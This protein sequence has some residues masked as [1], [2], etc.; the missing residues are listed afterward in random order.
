MSTVAKAV[1]LLDVLGRGEP[2][3]AL[4]DLARVAGFDKATTRRLLVALI[5]QGLVEQDGE[6][7]LYRLGVGIA[8][9]ALLRETQ[10]P[11]LRTATPIAQELAATTGETV[12]FSEHS[13]RGLVSIYV[14]ESPRAN[15][16]V[17]PLGEILPLHAT[18]SG[19]AFLA[20]SQTKT[21]ATALSG[22]LE[23]YTPHTVTD[24]MSVR[25]L[26]TAA[27][28]RGYSIG[29]Q[30]YEDGVTSV[31]API[32]GARGVAVGAIAIAAPRT[33]VQTGD[34]ETL[35]R[36]VMRAAAEISERLTGRRAKAANE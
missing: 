13:S 1:A 14:V 32:L 10:F 28:A 2:E 11:F 36:A 25:E 26:I 17:V 24:A 34:V 27:R 21:V 16:V 8:R 7:R 29:A 35:G 15:R 30:G 23:S 20:F 19:I 5:E 6:T 3:R 33:R 31:A 4:A 22:P 18:A 9:L 12:H